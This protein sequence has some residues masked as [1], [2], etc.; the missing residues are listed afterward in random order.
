MSNEVLGATNSLNFD[1]QEFKKIALE[2]SES[3]LFD[4]VDGLRYSNEETPLEFSNLL[5][6]MFEKKNSRSQPKNCL[7]LPT[8]WAEMF[9]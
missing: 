6:E 4:V 1:N 3:W 7:A 8:N 9:S 5:Q 2:S